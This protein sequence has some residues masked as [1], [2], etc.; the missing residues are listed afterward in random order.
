[1]AFIFKIELAYVE[2]PPVWRRVVVPENF[3]FLHFHY[4]IQ[5]AFGW[6]NAHYFQ[7]SP[8]GYGSQ[9]VIGEQVDEDMDVQES[10]EIELSQIFKRKG[11]TYT[12]IY[13][14]GDDWLHKIILEK[15]T[16]EKLLKADCLNGE[17][18]CP[19]E[20]CGGAPGYE[21]LKETLS[22]PKDPEHNETKEWL[23]LSKRQKWDA[24]AFD[25]KATSAAVRKV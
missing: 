7:F 11:Q 24:N 1:M 22:D 12:Y 13:D 21:Q 6:E 19:P 3:T 16:D 5:L 18:R 8:K 17:G 2:Q 4:V 23:G 10:Q 9:P 15:I 25:L 14:F 20:D